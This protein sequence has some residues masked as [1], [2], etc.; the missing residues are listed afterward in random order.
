MNQESTQLL[1]PIHAKHTFSIVSV[2]T[3]T[4]YLGESSSGWASRHMH[5]YRIA[6]PIDHMLEHVFL[7]SWAN[8]FGAFCEFLWVVRSYPI[9][10]Q[11]R[12]FWSC[13][14]HTFLGINF[15][16]SVWFCFMLD[17]LCF[18]FGCTLPPRSFAII[19][20]CI[21]SRMME[22]RKSTAA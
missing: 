21:A 9:S 20:Y 16:L 10:L 3:F 1:G 6:T 18:S 17:V 2:Y 15:A 4:N 19:N 12:G 5:C 14:F 11:R 22:L 7:L 8:Y 13:R